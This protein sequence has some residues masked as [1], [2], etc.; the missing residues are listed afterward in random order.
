M[1]KLLYYTRKPI[2]SNYYDA[3]IA[4]SMH[5]ALENDGKYVPLNHNSGVLFALATENEDGSLNPKCLKN[6]CVFKMRDG[7]FGISAI[8]T[9]GEGNADY[10][11][12]GSIVIFV[13]NDLI[14]YMTII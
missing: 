10:E 1:K 14:K 11:S 13:S 9:D 7:R 8:R 5:L 2:D 4:F 12:E 3:R 6:P